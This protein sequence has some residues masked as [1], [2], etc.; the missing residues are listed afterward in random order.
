[1]A[2]FLRFLFILLLIL[3]VYLPLSFPPSFHFP[4]S[5][6]YLSFSPFLSLSPTPLFLFSL[7]AQLPLLSSTST[8]TYV[9]LLLK[10]TNPSYFS[11]MNHLQI[12][13]H[14]PKLNYK[15]H[16]MIYLFFYFL[17]KKINIQYLLPCLT[18]TLSLISLLFLNYFT[19]RL[20]MNHHLF[21][22]F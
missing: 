2:S 3:A 6:I 18:K 22:F 17:I 16:F 19:V 1:M 10:K 15:I 21:L 7:S 5:P 12:I 8:V 14:M 4:R 9:V 13:H 11:A 20:K